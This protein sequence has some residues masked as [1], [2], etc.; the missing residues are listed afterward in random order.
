MTTTKEKETQ[1]SP[2]PESMQFS[3]QWE[4]LCET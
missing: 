2:S 3:S 4:I 1:E